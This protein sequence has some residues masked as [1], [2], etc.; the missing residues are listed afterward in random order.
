MSPAEVVKLP[1][2][3]WRPGMLWWV[4]SR[5]DG[6]FGRVEDACAEDWAPPDGAWP[7]PFDPATRGCLLGLV[8]EAWGPL[9]H[10]AALQAGGWAVWRLTP[11]GDHSWR[12]ERVGS[13]ATEWDALCA[14]LAAAPEGA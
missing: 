3:Q 12:S 13:G 5:E 7:E 10:A 11:I 4:G 8:R 1:G 14:A 9:V 6:D 2:W